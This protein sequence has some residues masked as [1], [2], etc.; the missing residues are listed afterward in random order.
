MVISS[1]SEFVLIAEEDRLQSRCLCS[2]WLVGVHPEQKV[3]VSEVVETQ[4]LTFRI[5]NTFG[6]L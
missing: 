5:S 6:L 3:V 4:N 2:I 1:A